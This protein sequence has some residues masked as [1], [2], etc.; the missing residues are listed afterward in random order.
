MG[1]TRTITNEQILEAAREVFLEDGFGGSTIEI[2]KRAGISEGS[3]FKRFSTKEK[4]FFASLGISETPNWVK[5]LETVVGQGDLKE[6]LIAVSLQIVE[7]LRDLVPRLTMLCSKGDLHKILGCDESPLVRDIRVLTK[8]FEEEVELGRLHIYN[9][10]I[11][12]RTLLGSLM[13]YVHLEYM[14]QPPEMSLPTEVY[15]TGLIDLLWQG[16]NGKT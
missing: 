10:A 13:N 4:L 1:R 14:G 2:A 3:I 12:A 6:N 7:F 8:F 9:P 11:A 5:D 16:M 15:V